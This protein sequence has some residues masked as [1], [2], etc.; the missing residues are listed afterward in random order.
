ML[1]K[2]QPRGEINSMAD[3]R[4][5]RLRRVLLKTAPVPYVL[6][7]AGLAT[8]VGAILSMFV[9]L[10]L[11]PIG[12]EP[13]LFLLL[14]FACL[15]C[16]IGLFII[17]AMSLPVLATFAEVYGLSGAS[18]KSPANLTESTAPQTG[19]SR[20]GAFGIMIWAGGGTLI[21]ALL[22]S[23]LMTG[24]WFYPAATS[25]AHVGAIRTFA[26]LAGFLCSFIGME[27]GKR[28]KLARGR[29]IS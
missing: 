22:A 6:W 21:G 24:H 5:E 9:W 28:R 2:T 1:P 4:Q 17:R 11:P 26:V 23:F 12:F 14:F 25:K 20:R 27:L 15:G 16:F 10:Q 7:M 13:F 18:A 3:G 19:T 29:P 8:I